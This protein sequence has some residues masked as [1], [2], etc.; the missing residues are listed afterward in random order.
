MEDPQDSEICFNIKN[1]QAEDK[2]K[3]GITTVTEVLEG[4]AYAV[5]N[6]SGCITFTGGEETVFSKGK[7]L[8]KQEALFTDNSASIRLVLWENNI[9][10]VTSASVYN[11]SKV[12][13]H[14][15][16]NAKYLTLNK[17]STIESCNVSIT[18]NDGDVEGL[19]SVEKVDC[20]PEGV[21]SLECFSSCKKCQTKLIRN[22]AK[23]LVKYT[24]CGLVQ[25]FD[26]CQKRLIA[27]VLFVK[28]E[29]RISLHLFEDNLKKLYDIYQINQFFL[30]TTTPTSN[31][32]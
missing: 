18:R 15:Y 21:L 4:D 2:C 5:M 32:S 25:L 27:N 28:L 6:V 30:L 26:K 10:R 16:D 11:L 23:K 13:V 29:K 14:E 12:V 19:R 24:E 17:T 31:P 3:P 9:N 22:G 7:A 8:C 1:V 20:P